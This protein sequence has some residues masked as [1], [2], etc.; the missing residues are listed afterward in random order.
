MVLF[1]MECKFFVCK[2]EFASVYQHH[3][4]SAVDDSTAQ[5]SMVCRFVITQIIYAIYIDDIS[6]AA[7]DRVVIRYLIVNALC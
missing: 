7:A 3:I 2:F 4:G 6:M 1:L 5:I